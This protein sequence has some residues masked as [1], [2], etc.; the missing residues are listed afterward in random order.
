MSAVLAERPGSAAGVEQPGRS[1]VASA[2]H[3][4]SDSGSAAS[5]ERP[6]RSS[7]E[8]RALAEQQAARRRRVGVVSAMHWPSDSAAA[9]VEQPQRSSVVSAVHWPSDLG[10]AASVE[11]PLR[12]SPSGVHHGQ[13][14]PA[15]KQVFTQVHQRSSSESSS[16]SLRRARSLVAA[17]ATSVHT[18]D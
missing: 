6:E 1:S 9:S 5:V 11:Q 10:S 8:R 17:A 13:R 16:R 18:A 7:V 14:G 15:M 2:M 12:L 3:W 4:P